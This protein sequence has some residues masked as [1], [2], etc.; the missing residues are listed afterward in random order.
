MPATIN[1]S[2]R[3]FSDQTVGQTS[4]LVPVR[5]GP[6]QLSEAHYSSK[7]IDCRAA[8]VRLHRL[9]LFFP[10]SDGQLF[11][12]DVGGIWKEVSEFVLR[13]INN[14]FKHE[15]PS[16]SNLVGSPSGVEP[17]SCR[18]VEVSACMQ[19]AVACVVKMMVVHEQ[20]CSI[21]RQPK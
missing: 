4:P 15:P 16:S 1:G 10:R 11:H 8:S 2:Y 18:S 7:S 17:G 14:L 13:I 3:L 5:S 12:V 9:E 19:V 21:F 6:D 20:R